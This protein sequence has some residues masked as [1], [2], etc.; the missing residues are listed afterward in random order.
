M[1]ILEEEVGCPSRPAQG[2]PLTVARVQGQM[3]EHE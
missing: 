2:L 1:A 3:I